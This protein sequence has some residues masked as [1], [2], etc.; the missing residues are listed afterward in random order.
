MSGQEIR[1]DPP[2]ADRGGRDLADAGHDIAGVRTSLGGAIMAA[3]GDRPWG[4]DDIG[5]QFQPNY[6]AGEKSIMDAWATI[7]AYVEALGAAAVRSVADLT[8]ADAQSAER[9][10]DAYRP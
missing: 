10:R 5:A 6:A 9:V 3:S 7:A 2:R 8:A 1:L 4:S